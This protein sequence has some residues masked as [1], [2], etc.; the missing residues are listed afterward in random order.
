MKNGTTI[1]AKIGDVSRRAPIRAFKIAAVLL[2]P[3]V[4]WGFGIDLVHLAGHL[5]HVVLGVLETLAVSL[6]VQL[7]GLS[8]RAAQAVAAYSGLTLAIIFTIRMGYRIY[9]RVR[10]WVERLENSASVMWAARHWRLL[11]AGTAALS[12]LWLTQL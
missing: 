11:V 4:V 8:H 9:L 7:F 5:L 1:P 12:A 2:C 3:L 10:R 6:G